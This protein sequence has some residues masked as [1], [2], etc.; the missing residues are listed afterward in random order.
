MRYVINNEWVENNEEH[1]T[2]RLP[3]YEV[4][5]K[6]KYMPFKITTIRENPRTGTALKY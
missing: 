2:G 5:E 3:K 1:S 6:N 4:Y